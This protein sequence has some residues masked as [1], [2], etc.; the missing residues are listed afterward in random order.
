[1]QLALT[2]LKSKDM[3]VLEA[4]C[5]S[6]RVIKFLYDMGYSNVL[7]IELNH[8]AVFETKKRYPE[9]MIEQGDIMSMAIKPNKFD[10]VLCF[11]VIEHFTMG[12]QLPL[13]KIYD[14]LKQRGIAIVSVPSI[15]KIRDFIDKVGLELVGRNTLSYIYRNKCFPKRN[16][17]ELPYYCYPKY[18]EFFEYR[19]RPKQFEHICSETGFTIL[20]SKPVAH[21]DGLFHLLGGNTPLVRFDN[22]QFRVSRVGMLLNNVLQAIPFCHNHMHVCVLIKL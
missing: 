4:G 12:P 5:G 16:R 10:M 2:Y 9:L 14:V 3:T 18:G 6:G 22:W 17:Q 1:V 15:N 11:G 13:K 19:F 21:I 20:E 7:G 8:E